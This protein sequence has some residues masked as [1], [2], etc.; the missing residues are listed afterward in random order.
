[1]KLGNI[2]EYHLMTIILSLTTF[3]SFIGSYFLNL[4]LDHSKQYIAVLGVILID[5]V[6]GIMAG[7]KREGFKTYKALRILKTAV[8]WVVFLTVILMIEEGF[9]GAGWIS[10][11]IVVP[12]L[13]FQII[14]AL[15]NAS[16]AGFV[17]VDDLNSILEKVDRHKGSLGRGSSKKEDE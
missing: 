14:S 15:K 6:F 4:T 1:M 2:M 12:F 3:L 7:V 10:T 16:M 9:H 13:L 5:G 11:T 17:K 8:T